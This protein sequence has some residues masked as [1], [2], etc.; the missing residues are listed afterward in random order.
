VGRP[1]RDL[2]ISYRPLEL[3]SLIERSEAESRQITAKE[4]EWHAPGTE[5]RW[6]DVTVGPL[7]DVKGSHLGSL[8]TFADVTSH[9]RLQREL[10]RSHQEL[11]TAYEELQC[12]NEALETM[13]EELQSTNQELQT[14]KDEFRQRGE[15]L[16]SA[17]AFLGSVLT[18]LKGGVAVV[19]RELRLLAWNAQAEELWGVRGEEARGRHLLNLDIGLPLERLRSMLKSCMGDHS[20]EQVLRL[21]AVNRRG[22]AIKCT[23]NCTPLK[24]ADGDI[25]GAIVWMEE[26]ESMVRDAVVTKEAG[27]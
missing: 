13:N 5:I 21:E 16:N 8:I 25:Q 15:D 11:E 3:R 26:F 12:T 14:M 10:E 18:S 23:V 24:G 7:A 4:V 6:L 19:D 20:G 22:K 17:N 1:F 9:R 27:G 2:Q